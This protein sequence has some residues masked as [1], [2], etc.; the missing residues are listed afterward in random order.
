M[1]KNLQHGEL[2]LRTKKKRTISNL[3]L[4][5]EEF[6]SHPIESSAESSSRELG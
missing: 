4:P 6:K 5:K 2:T 1:K 3:R